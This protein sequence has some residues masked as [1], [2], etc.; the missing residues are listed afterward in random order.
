MRSFLLVFESHSVFP[1][2]IREALDELHL[3]I[4]LASGQER[5]ETC[6]TAVAAKIQ[7][8][9]RCKTQDHRYGEW[10]LTWRGVRG[11]Y[12]CSVVAGY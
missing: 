7:I 6:D 12:N 11:P 9:I 10:R 3:R 4:T 5:N 1:S 8:Q 2:G